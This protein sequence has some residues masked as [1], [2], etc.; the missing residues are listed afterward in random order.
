MHSDQA[1]HG[2]RLHA[3]VWGYRDEILLP[4]SSGNNGFVIK[5]DSSLQSSKMLM[6]NKHRNWLQARPVTTKLEQ[7]LNTAIAISYI[8]TSYKQN[9]TKLQ[10]SSKYVKTKN[11]K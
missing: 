5:G 11:N 2:P 4:A 10:N 6:S 9:A 1:D 8:A 3:P 7:K